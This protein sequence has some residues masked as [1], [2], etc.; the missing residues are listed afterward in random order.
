MD[1]HGAVAEAFVQGV[2][3]VDDDLVVEIADAVAVDDG[4][5]E[6]FGDEG[7]LGAVRAGEPDHFEGSALAELDDLAGLTGGTSVA[8]HVRSFPSRFDRR[9][10]PAP[11]GPPFGRGQKKPAER[12]GLQGPH[13][14]GR[15]NLS[16][17]P[18]GLI[19]PSRSPAGPVW[20]GWCVRPPRGA[21]A[22]LKAPAAGLRPRPEPKGGRKGWLST[23]AQCEGNDRGRFAYAPAI[24]IRLAHP[25]WRSVRC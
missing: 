5:T 9:L 13:G 7:G 14:P 22:A 15:A 21:S 25:L 12:R 16:C 20:R 8:G 3:R 10:E 2:G 6:A 23:G 18:A 4:K 17:G 11:A 24:T 19:K 1:L